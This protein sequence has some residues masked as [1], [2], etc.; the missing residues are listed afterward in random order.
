MK[1]V[2]AAP[3]AGVVTR[4]SRK[5]LQPPVGWAAVAAARDDLRHRVHGALLIATLAFA[6]RN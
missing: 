1:P 5:R 4:V 3:E 2:D 6:D